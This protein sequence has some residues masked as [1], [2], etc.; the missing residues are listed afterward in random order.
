VGTQDR[1][2]TG[3]NQ[4]TINSGAYPL[5][6][7]LY[8]EHHPT[9]GRWLS[10]DPA[11]LAAVNPSGPQTWNRY[12]Y[13]MN[14]PTGLTDPLGLCQPANGIPC[15]PVYEPSTCDGIACSSGS[16]GNDPF[17]GLEY[18]FIEGFEGGEN[19]DAPTFYYIFNPD[20]AYLQA[21][22][23]GG[24]LA[25]LPLRQWTG[26]QL[27]ALL[28]S[29]LQVT[30]ESVDSYLGEKNSPMVGQGNNFVTY[31]VGNGV[32]PR[33]LVALA[34]AESSF[35]INTNATWGFYNPFG[36]SSG[37]TSW[38]NWGQGISTVA[39]GI[40]G[41]RYFR[42][43]RTSTSSI[44]MGTYCEG[45]GCARGLNNMNT[46]LTQQGGNPNNVTCP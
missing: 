39:A 14:N 34:G 44:Y 6:D 38:T 25:I 18:L 21:F 24:G 42:A 9:W 29:C 22:G 3:Q 4:D 28:P 45:P 43:G 20:A 23:P 41:P 33:F 10:P 46:F 13:V 26:Q 40:A 37:G 5:Y 16:A 11:G 17:L 1:N 30:A 15:H 19:G 12:A 27:L 2:F 32:D 35:G 8:R 31:G 36:W 7:F